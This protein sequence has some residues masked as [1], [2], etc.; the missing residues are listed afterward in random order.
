MVAL[1]LTA[2]A[3]D[4]GAPQRCR[5]DTLPGAW[6]A[7]GSGNV[8]VFHQDGRLSCEGSCRFTAATGQPLSW[9]YDD[10]A[11]IWSS[12]IDYVKLE[13][14][15][16]TFEGVFGA[17]RCYIEDGGRVLRLQPEDDRPMVFTRQ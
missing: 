17:F 11:N 6:R 4:P 8:W 10:S 15:K 3:S 14:E 7:L 2:C 9:A 5:A 13:F 16:G 12:P 1:V